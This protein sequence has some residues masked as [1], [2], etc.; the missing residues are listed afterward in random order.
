MVDLNADYEV[1]A[2]SVGDTKAGT[3]MG[4]LQLRNIEENSTL[5]CILW[6]ETLNRLDSKLFRTGNVVKITSASFNEKFNNCLVNNMEII[7]NS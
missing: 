2:Y 6:E 7:K 1:M 3:K 4:K 5:N